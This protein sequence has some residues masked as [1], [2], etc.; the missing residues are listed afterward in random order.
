MGDRVDG[1]ST[2][3]IWSLFYII[4]GKIN[5]ITRTRT[6]TILVHCLIG[7]WEVPVRIVDLA[8]FAGDFAEGECF[9]R[10]LLGGLVRG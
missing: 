9:V 7:R 2:V 3:R 10:L 5:K 6:R 4:I 8:G 1:V